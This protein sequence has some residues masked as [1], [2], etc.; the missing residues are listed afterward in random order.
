[1]GKNR[2]NTEFGSSRHRMGPPT[3]QLIQ[4]AQLGDDA[5]FSSDPELELNGQE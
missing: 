3:D 4:H 1:M 2:E 5:V